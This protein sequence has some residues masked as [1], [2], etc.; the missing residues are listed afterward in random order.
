MS[1]YRL[2]T[3][4]QRPSCKVKEVASGKSKTSAIYFLALVVGM[5]G[6][7]YASVRPVKC[8]APR[9][10]MLFYSRNEGSNRVSM[11]WRAM[12]ARPSASVPLYRMFCQATGFGG[13]TKR[14]TIEDKLREQ[15]KRPQAGPGADATDSQSTCTPLPPPPPPCVSP[16]SRGL[17]S[18][19]CKLNRGL[20]G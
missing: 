3:C 7:T 10:R 1:Q 11:M 20:V 2:S 14:K 9:H 15:A 19:P 16:P 12:S 4:H 5:V 17:P 8:C 18:F 6:V 13:T